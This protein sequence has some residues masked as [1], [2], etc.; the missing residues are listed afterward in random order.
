MNPY[1]YLILLN[2]LN[3]V[4]GLEDDNLVYAL[5]PSIDNK[6]GYMNGIYSHTLDKLP[7]I[8]DSSLEIFGGIRVGAAKKSYAY[9]RLKE[10]KENFIK[11]LTDAKQLLRLREIKLGNNKNDA[12]LAALSHIYLSSFIKPVQFFLPHSSICSGQWDFWDKVNYL[13]LIEKIHQKE[14]TKLL[15]KKLLKNDVWKTKFKADDFPEIV[16]RRLLKEKLLG[17]KLGSNAMIKAMIIRMGELA[18]PSIN[19]EVIDF[20]IRSFFTYLGVKKYLRVD[21]EILFLR[22]LE[23][24]LE[25]I[26][27]EM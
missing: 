3:E 25:K 9:L 20:S 7:L 24:E 18:K 17:E 11:I 2:K 15:S 8:V 5:T 13:E 16:K 21:R 14:T 10:E 23:K 19:Y 22:T 1:I 4:C 12:A 6:L 27:A 26:L